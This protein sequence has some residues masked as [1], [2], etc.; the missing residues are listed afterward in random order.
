MKDVLDHRSRGRGRSWCME[1][2]MKWHEYS[3]FELT[4]ELEVNLTNCARM[5]ALY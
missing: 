3:V 4:W 5:L 2:I 1:Y